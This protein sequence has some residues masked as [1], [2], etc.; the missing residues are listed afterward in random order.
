MN[1]L[2]G[3]SMLMSRLTDSENVTFWNQQAPLCQ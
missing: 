3:E 1:S 2:I